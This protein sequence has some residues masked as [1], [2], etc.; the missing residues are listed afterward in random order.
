MSAS[1]PMNPTQRPE[2]LKVVLQ[3]IVAYDL[4]LT[5]QEHHGTSKNLNRSIECIVSNPFGE[6][7]KESDSDASKCLERK[8]PRKISGE[9]ASFCFP[10]SLKAIASPPLHSTARLAWEFDRVRAAYSFCHP[11]SSIYHH[12]NDNQGPRTED[13]DQE[14]AT[15]NKMSQ[16]N[17]PRCDDSIRAWGKQTLTLG[18]RL[19]LVTKVWWIPPSEH[20]ACRQRSLW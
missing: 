6:E 15:K 10:S 7:V 11:N 12:N 17:G 13:Q 3:I 2:W 8:K 20:S 16:T 19:W 18:P 4:R 14:S 1:L 9:S 5:T